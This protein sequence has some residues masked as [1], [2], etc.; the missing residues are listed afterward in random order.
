M[1]INRGSAKRGLRVGD[2]KRESAYVGPSQVF[3]DF[4]PSQA[5][6][7]LGAVL[8]AIPEGASHVQHLLVGAGGH[9]GQS[10]S[11]DATPGDGGRAEV[12]GGSFALAA[13]ATY[14][15]SFSGGIV[16]LRRTLSGSTTTLASAKGGGGGGGQGG[17]GVGSGGKGYGEGGEGSATFGGG[18]GGGQGQDGQDGIDGGAGR[19]GGASRN[20]NNGGD[21][22]SY[23]KPLGSLLTPFAGV[24]QEDNAIRYGG[25]DYGGPQPH[26]TNGNFI[27]HFN[28]RLICKFLDRQP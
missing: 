18:G 28:G 22:Y 14:A 16:S 13:G 21:G 19:G 10:Q 7:G 17:T 27:Y 4:T 15:L 9:K 8:A 26:L 2:A 1:P 3:D 5:D 20:G 6:F 12:V 24:A 23:S 11:A 25:T